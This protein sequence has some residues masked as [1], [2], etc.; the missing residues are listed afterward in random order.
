[1]IYRQNNFAQTYV[2][3][4]LLYAFSISNFAEWIPS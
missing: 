1:M 3:Q 2:R 4:E